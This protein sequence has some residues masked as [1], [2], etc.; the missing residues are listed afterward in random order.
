MDRYWCLLFDI[1]ISHISVSNITYSACETKP[2]FVVLFIYFFDLLKVKFFLSILDFYLTQ[3]I[4]N[5][6]FRISTLST[7]KINCCKCYY[8]CQIVSICM[9]RIGDQILTPPLN[10][11][12]KKVKLIFHCTI[13][14]F[15][16]V[17]NKICF[18]NHVRPFKLI[19]KF[20]L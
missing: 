9:A 4:S 1:T 12:G 3:L 7:P 2:P 20:P 6:K 15:W 8:H 17:I 16:Y 11:R 19:N 18:W 13:I 5:K 10:R 14:W